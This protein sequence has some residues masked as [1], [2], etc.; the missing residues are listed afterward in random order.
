MPASPIVERITEA[1]RDAF[2]GFAPEKVVP[3]VDGV[4]E[5]LVDIPDALAESLKG[6]A[7]RLED[8]LPIHAAVPEA[9]RDLIPVVEGLRE[10]FAEA[11]TIFRRE[12]EQ[13]LKQHY[14]PRAGEKAWN[15]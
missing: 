1:I 12:H 9:L 15:V 14:E 8:D 3:D 10:R 13:E 4:M 7:S 2:K 6:L 11:N 5:H